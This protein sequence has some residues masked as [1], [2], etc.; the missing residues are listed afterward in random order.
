MNRLSPLAF[1]G[2]LIATGL[3]V[4]ASAPVQ[5]AT[6][7]VHYDD[8]DLST[9][10]GRATLDSR[11]SHAAHAVCWIENPTLSASEAC[12]RASIANAHAAVDRAIQSQSIQLAS[13]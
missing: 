4:M 6:A 8:L 5:A 9:A 1:A 2:A 3:T 10:G 7:H 11:V 12:R 13:R